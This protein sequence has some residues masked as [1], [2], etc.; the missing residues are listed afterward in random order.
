MVLGIPYVIRISLYGN[1]FPQMYVQLLEQE[2]LHSSELHNVIT[3]ARI[4]VQLSGHWLQYNITYSSCLP[5]SNAYNLSCEYWRINMSI[6]KRKN[7][8]AGFVAQDIILSIILLISDTL[9]IYLRSAALLDLLPFDFLEVIGTF[10]F[11]W[12]HVILRSP[13]IDIR[14]TLKS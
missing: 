11:D 4:S 14:A 5:Q 10:V 7:V 13:K 9:Q 8:I 6:S 3:I 1:V 12:H 2:A